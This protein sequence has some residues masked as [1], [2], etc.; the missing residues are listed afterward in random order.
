MATLNLNDTKWDFVLVIG[1]EQ[2]AT[3]CPNHETTIQM[4]ELDARLNATT[5]AVEKVK[6]IAEIQALLLRFVSPSQESVIQKLLPDD[7][8]QAFTGCCAYWMEHIK[9]KCR[10]AMEAATTPEPKI[11]AAPQTPSVNCGN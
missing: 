5:D 2:I 1:N 10:A 7:V 9:K 3:Y 11:K 4:A 6:I 8:L